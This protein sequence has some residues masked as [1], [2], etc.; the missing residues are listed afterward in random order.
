MQPNQINA[1]IVP[2]FFYLLHASDAKSR[3]DG[4]ERLQRDIKELVDAADEQVTPASFL[5]NSPIS[6]DF[7]ICSSIV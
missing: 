1:R 2:S 4:I 3:N 6:V 5:A 7:N